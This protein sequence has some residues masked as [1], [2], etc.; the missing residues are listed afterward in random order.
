MWSR[1]IEL[2]GFLPLI[3]TVRNKGSFFEGKVIPGTRNR[4]KQSEEVANRGIEIFNVLLKRINPQYLL[5]V[6]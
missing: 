4:I 1:R 6:N 2:D 3:H 5:R